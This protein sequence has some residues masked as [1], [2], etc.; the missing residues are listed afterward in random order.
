VDTALSFMF[1]PHLPPFPGGER[2]SELFPGLPDQAGDPAV[3]V[4]RVEV[5]STRFLTPPARA[6]LVPSSQ[7]L[8]PQPCL[9]GIPGE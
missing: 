4:V 8:C 1:D 2:P 3:I 9:T 6:S 7:V 5:G